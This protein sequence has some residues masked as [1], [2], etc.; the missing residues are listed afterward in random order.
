MSAIAEEEDPFQSAKTRAN[1]KF[2][3]GLFDEAIELY[4][5]ALDVATEQKQRAVVLANRAHAFLSAEPPQPD[6]ALRDA[7][8]AVMLAP[9]YVKAH[10]R[11]SKALAATGHA[12]EASEAMARSKA[13]AMV[14]R[15]ARS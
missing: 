13:L 11:L 4:T 12:P 6:D 1:D 5:A 7:S 8:Q 2:R 3:E 15:I 9:R 14:V 10:Y